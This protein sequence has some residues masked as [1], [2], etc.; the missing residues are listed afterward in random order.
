MIVSELHFAFPV[1]P[2]RQINE[3]HRHGIAQNDRPVLALRN[4]PLD[5]A[6]PQPSS[7]RSKK[8][9]SSIGFSILMHPCE[10]ARTCRRN[11]ARE[12]IV[13]VNAV[14]IGNMNLIRP[15]AFRAPGSWRRR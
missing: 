8:V 1:E 14:R 5:R 10:N 11:N 12:G 15:S 7:P 6:R 9:A 3:V 4:R 2:S 13:K